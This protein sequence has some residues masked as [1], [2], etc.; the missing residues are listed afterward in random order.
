MYRPA[1]S[2]RPAGSAG[3]HSMK[4]R[5]GFVWD[6]RYMWHDTG[7]VLMPPWP[8]G[9]AEP[10]PVWEAPEGKRRLKNLLDAT[11]VTEQL[12]PLRAV[13]VSQ[14][15]VLR[16]HT[17]DYVARLRALSDDRG[18]DGGDGATPFGAGSLDI[19][20]LSAGGVTAAAHA[21]ARREVDNAYALV[22]PPGHHALPAMGMG[23]CL[24]NN[25]GIAI[26]DLIATGVA[27]RIAVID[28]DVHHGNGTQDV[29]WND[30]D[31]LTVSIHQDGKFPLDTGTVHE[32][33]DGPGFGA[34]VNVPLPAGS[35]N[36]A[37]RYAIEQVVEPAVQ[38]FGPDMLVIA[39]GFDA[40]LFD[41]LGRQMVTAGTFGWMA[42]RMV[43]LAE[44]TCDGRL[45]VVHEGGYSPQYVP[46]CGLRVVEALSGIDAQA[47][48]G[49]EAWA[50]QHPGQELLPHQQQAVDAAAK[51][52]ADIPGR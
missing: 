13:P 26:R 27:Q 17:A 8:T 12:T 14:E 49:A 30:P 9:W 39:C 32:R 19:A 31:V 22:R 48:D 11:G 23:F 2:G 43:A 41:P 3:M 50:S 18:G 29:F 6:E 5:T 47:P 51:L 46:F 24:L 20:L 4:R 37:Y 7:N 28:W 52:I 45:L 15:A 16:V 34:N 35:G 36:G 38:R 44:Q 21:V 25:I 42:D 33:G 10:Y 40:N 1:T